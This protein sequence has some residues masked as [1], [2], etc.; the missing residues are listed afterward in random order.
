ML[1]SIGKVPTAFFFVDNLSLYRNAP[2]VAIAPG[3]YRVFA[4]SVSLVNDGSPERYRFVVSI[5]RHPGYIGYPAS[6]ND[7]AVL[8]VSMLMITCFFSIQNKFKGSTQYFNT[9]SEIFMFKILG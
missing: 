7:V 1:T 6:I 9:H 3:D 8:T 5:D 2:P 4:G